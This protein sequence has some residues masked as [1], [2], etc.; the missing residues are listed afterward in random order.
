MPAYLLDTNVLVLTAGRRAPYD[1][2][3]GKALRRLAV[4]G[5]P[6][7]VASQVLV[8]FWV[9][10]TRPADVNGLAWTVA[11][12]FAEIDRI[13]RQFPLLDDRP[14]AFPLWLDLVHRTGTSGKHAHDARLASVMRANGVFHILTFNVTTSLPASAFIPSIQTK[15]PGKRRIASEDSRSRY[16]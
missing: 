4:R 11:E 1:A 7:F 2:I 10:A 14:Q 13:L 5:D 3:A 6:C 16:R 8:E 12:T 9:V 15:S